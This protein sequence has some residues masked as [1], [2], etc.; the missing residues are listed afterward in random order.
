[1]KK[2]RKLKKKEGLS[3]CV[4]C[5]AIATDQQQLCHAEPFKGDGEC[6]IPEKQFH[7][8]PEHGNCKPK[9]FVCTKC[10]REALSDEYLCDAQAF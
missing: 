9:N 8:F 5:G 4:R 1:M 3:V 7:W 6:T 2:K 10:G